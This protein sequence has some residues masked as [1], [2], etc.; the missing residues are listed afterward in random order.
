MSIARIRSKAVALA[1][2]RKI[3]DSPV[4]VDNQDS[5]FEIG[6][7]TKVFTASLLADP[8]RHHGM[9]LDGPIS[10]D[11]PFPLREP[12]KNGKPVTYRT[13]ADHTSGLS[14]DPDNNTFEMSPYNPC[15]GYCR[16]SL[17]RYLRNLMSLDSTPGQRHLYSNLGFGLLGHLLEVKPG[18]SCERLLQKKFS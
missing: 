13:L 3:S 2:V 11:L 7:I 14:R 10:G 4:F 9:G 6:S 12:G 17:K 15:M 1:G 16:D 8:I 18:K 5:V